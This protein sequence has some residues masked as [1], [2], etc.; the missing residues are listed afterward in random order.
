MEFLLRPL[1]SSPDE[2]QKSNFNLI[3]ISFYKWCLHQNVALWKHD[4]FI[5]VKRITLWTNLRI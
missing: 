3:K 1:A 5:N 2:R 4:V